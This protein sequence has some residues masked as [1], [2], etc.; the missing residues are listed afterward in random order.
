MKLATYRTEHAEKIGALTTDGKRLVDLQAASGGA[1]RFATMLSLIDAGEAGLAEARVLVADAERTGAD[2]DL[3]EAVTLMAPIPVPPQIRDFSVFPTHIV[4]APTGMKKLAAA[5]KGDPIPE[6]ETGDVPAVYRAQPIYYFT[7]RFSVVGSDTTVKWPR[8]SAYMDFE[9]EL[10]AVLSKGGKD[11]SVETA[12]DHIFGYTIFN[13]F[14]ARDAQLVEMGGM[15]GP[16]KGKSFDAG[17][18]FGPFLVTKDEI[19]DVAALTARV[20]INGTQYMSDDCSAMLHSFEE[21]I[22]FVSRDETL[23][24]GEI[25]G[26]GT[27][28][29]GCGLEHF[30]FLDDGDVLELEIDGIGVL[31][32]TVVRQ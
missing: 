1:P 4:Q 12:G 32:N 15:L 24:A 7:N 20:R 31:R 28:G 26:S 27:V 2:C 8:Y 3:L 13:D 5:L 25:F 19:P 9:I 29:N 30:T 18:A 11:I 21:M 17:N 14:S 22:A 6:I 10:A 23:H 16:A